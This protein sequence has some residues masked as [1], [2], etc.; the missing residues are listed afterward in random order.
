[1]HKGFAADLFFR[2]DACSA[3]RYSVQGR[4]ESV[5]NV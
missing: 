3:M 1:M 4:K 2:E 5:G